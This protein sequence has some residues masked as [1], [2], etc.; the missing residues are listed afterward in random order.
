MNSAL[1][2]TGPDL[3]TVGT[4]VTFQPSPWNN[5]LLWQLQS[6]SLLLTDPLGGT[7]TVAA[8]GSGVNWAATWTVIGVNGSGA[9]VTGTWVRAWSVVG[10]DGVPAVSVPETF[11]VINSPGTPF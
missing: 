7:Y 6:A 3:F 5:G 10:T 9:D 2:S 8:T 1:I 11:R 4:R